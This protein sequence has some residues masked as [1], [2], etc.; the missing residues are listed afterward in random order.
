MKLDFEKIKE[1]CTG[2]VRIE[3]EGEGVRFYRF[4]EKQE[5][6]YKE[7][8]DDFYAKS[9]ATAGVRLSFR[10]DSKALCLRGETMSSRSRA[11]YSIDVFADGRP[12][13]YIDNFSSA[14]LP[15]DY[16]KTE[17]PFGLFRGEFALGE[18]DKEVTVYLPWSVITRIDEISVDNGAYVQ[19]LMPK[20]TLL[21]FGDSIT[22]G[23]DALRSSNR[24]TARLCDALSLSEIN[25]AI[26]G[27]IF[28]G[29]LASEREDII[30]DYITV[31]YGT[32]DWSFVQSEEMK[33]SC[34]EFF[35]SL[36]KNYPEAKIFA[37]TPIWRKDRTEE[38]KYGDFL[39]VA[40][41]IREAANG[42]GVIFIDGLDFVPKE[43]KYFADLRLHPNDEGFEYYFNNLLA[44]IKENI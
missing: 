2:A 38:R 13:G 28:W 23:Y 36:R 18:G 8:R 9:F 27:E 24:Y 26:G 35:S 4:S 34:R 42:F 29:E 6:L 3:R 17:L 12:V 21:A 14:E 7:R 1:I 10:T 11:Y 40:G 16:T 41:D 32:N 33:E 30:P 39:S 15:L 44:K 22:Q 5:A 25:K 31:A 20:K 19:P 43:E 37:I